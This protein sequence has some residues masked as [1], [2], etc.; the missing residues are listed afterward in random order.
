MMTLG[1]L[2][3]MSTLDGLSVIFHIQRGTEA[4]HGW[5]G[6]GKKPVYILCD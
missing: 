4:P 2:G 6:A 3:L 5:Y 1:D